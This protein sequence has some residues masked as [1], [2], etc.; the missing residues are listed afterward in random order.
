M[1]IYYGVSGRR[2]DRYAFVSVYFYT[3]FFLVFVSYWAYTLHKEGGRGREKNAR[4]ATMLACQDSGRMKELGC[5]T[6]IC[7]DQLMSL[8][9]VIG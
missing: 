5:K 9:T 4:H 3:F 7:V 8:W 1:H 6:P 2:N